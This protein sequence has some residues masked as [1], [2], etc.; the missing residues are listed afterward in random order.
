MS[1][2]RKDFE[3]L[4]LTSDERRSLV[5]GGPPVSLPK[6]SAAR[7]GLARLGRYGAAQADDD[8]FMD[9]ALRMM[10]TTVP[11]YWLDGVKLSREENLRFLQV[12]EGWSREQAEEHLERVE[13]DNAEEARIFGGGA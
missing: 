9:R 10:A 4:G 1:T 13:K 2:S 7:A 3:G 8:L 6:L 5:F 12:K 11:Q